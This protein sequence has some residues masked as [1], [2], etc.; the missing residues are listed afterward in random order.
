M[1]QSATPKPAHPD[2]SKPSSR[3]FQPLLEAHRPVIVELLAKYTRAELFD[4][5]RAFPVDNAALRA[6]FPASAYPG[7][8][9]RYLDR[10]AIGVVATY[11]AA[12]LWHG[13]SKLLTRILEL[14]Q[15]ELAL[16][17]TANA[18]LEAA[19]AKQ[20]VAV[21]DAYRGPR[22]PDEDQVHP[23]QVPGGTAGSS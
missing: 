14:R 22:D 8:G 19:V 6:L 20:A 18:I 3:R 12:L 15:Q 7:A 16:V 2:D 23:H 9:F 21:K 11:V 17:Q 4:L 13:H 1:D 10:A 5:A